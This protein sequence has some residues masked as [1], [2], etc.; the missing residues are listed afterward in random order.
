MMRD[1]ARRQALVRTLLDDLA[2]GSQTEIVAALAR[3]GIAAHPAT[4][5]RDLEEIG[6]RKVRDASGGLAYRVGRA[7]AT[8]SA[9]LDDVLG[10]FV[11]AVDH[12]GAMVVLRTPP[13]CAHPV[14][15]AID[16]TPP[17]GVIATLAGDDTVL[18]VVADGASS[19]TIADDLARR[20]GMDTHRARG[21]AG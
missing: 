17:S 9:A 6:A 21:A 10:R 4:V 16:A 12:S 15:S 1:K 20:C 2:L 18:V 3:R 5:S 7:G 11:T 13:A 8:P 19:R 14:A